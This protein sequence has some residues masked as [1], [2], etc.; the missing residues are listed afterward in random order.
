MRDSLRDF[1]GQTL[2]VIGGADM[3]GRE[4]C[5]V[6]AS[7]PAWKRLVEGP[8]VTWRR[9]DGAD[10]TFSRRAWRDQVAGWTCE[11]VRAL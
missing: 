9:L 5:D 10:H 4:F 7:T 3:T 1:G 6:A 8:R 2:L 11:W